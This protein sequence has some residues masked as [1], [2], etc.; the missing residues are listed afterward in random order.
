MLLNLRTYL[1]WYNIQ[2]QVHLHAMAISTQSCSLQ[3][4]LRSPK[5]LRALPSQRSGRGHFPCIWPVLSGP[6]AS[7]PSIWK[8]LAT[9]VNFLCILTQSHTQ[10]LELSLATWLPET[11]L[12]SNLHIFLNSSILLRPYHLLNFESTCERERPVEGIDKFQLN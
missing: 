9:P 10:H 12:Y 1:S 3:P 5:T 2:L 11:E 4:W 7:H 8:S 6:T